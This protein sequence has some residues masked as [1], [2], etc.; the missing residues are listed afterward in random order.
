M[1]LD[2][3]KCTLP[4]VRVSREIITSNGC[5]VTLMFPR[6]SDARIRNEVAHML[7]VAFE[8]KEQK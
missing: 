3:E 4:A 1:N 5:K 6:Q 2:N 7:F 8:Q